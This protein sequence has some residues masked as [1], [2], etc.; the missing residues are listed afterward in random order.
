MARELLRLRNEKGLSD[1][2]SIAIFLGI[3]LVM[4]AVIGSIALSKVPSGTA[5]TASIAI[6]SMGNLVT[7]SH[8]GG[9]GIDYKN[10]RIYLY[11]YPELNLLP[12]YPTVGDTTAKTDAEPIGVFNNGDIIK[13]QNLQK[14]VYKVSIEYVPLQQMIAEALVT[15][16]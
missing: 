12:G 13:I 3:V 8:R 15:V 5:P 16:N 11:T 14:G 4:T 10:L 7:I 6:Q 2:V 9:E 1:A